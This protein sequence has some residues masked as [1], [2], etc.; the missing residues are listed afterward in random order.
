MKS[1]SHRL[2]A[3]T[4]LV[5]LPATVAAEPEE[6]DAP[7]GVEIGTTLT[8]TA[9]NSDSEVNEGVMAFDVL[10]TIPTAS[11]NWGLLVEAF[12]H[13]VADQTRDTA[14][15]ET[16]HGA[17][18]QAH[19]GSAR[20]AELHYGFRALGGDWSVGLLDSKVHID[21][22][23]V[24]NDDKEQFLGAAFVNNPAIA[25]PDSSFGVA[26]QHAPGAHAPGYTVLMTA[27]ETRVAG[28]DDPVDSLFLA[29]EASREIG[30]L[31]ARLG[32]WTYGTRH[33]FPS[34]AGYRA[35]DHGFYVSVDGQS[36]RMGWNLRGGSARL[37]GLAKESFL[38]AAALIPVRQNVFGVGVGHS[39]RSG[40]ALTGHGGRTSY[41]EFFYRFNA[42]GRFSVTPDI[43][44]QR[45]TGVPGA[46][47]VFSACLRLRVVI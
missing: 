29:L 30:G 18:G 39:I 25:I 8:A 16:G 7:G 42:L 45:I 34:E 46:R 26:Y 12:T 19:A 1:A 47:N 9:D 41:L 6:R 32:A 21:G 11:G 15:F 23:D 22:S 28:G 31:T 20:L 4:L 2:I 17:W 35:R 36:A 10:T 40:R 44:Y 37:G 33:P 5:A 27:T 43:Q 13:P 14:A 24:A 38:G 3:A